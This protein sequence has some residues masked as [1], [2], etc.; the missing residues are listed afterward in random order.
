[1]LAD[2]YISK[3]YEDRRTD[4]SFHGSNLVQK[5]GPLEKTF[6]FFEMCFP[7]VFDLFSNV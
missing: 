4:K 5:F 1:M 2:F 7:N 3:W 6:Q